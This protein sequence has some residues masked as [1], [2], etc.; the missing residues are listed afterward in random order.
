MEKKI[1][2]FFVVILQITPCQDVVPR[3][4]AR[5]WKPPWEYV[6]LFRIYVSL[7]TILKMLSVFGENHHEVVG[8][9]LISHYWC[10]KLRQLYLQISLQ[11]LMIWPVGKILVKI[12]ETGLKICHFFVDFSRFDW[13][14]TTGFP[15]FFDQNF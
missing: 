1:K 8:H 14:Q 10:Y 7:S 11:P 9:P 12:K 2:H 5:Y 3:K 4:K 15:T 6:S 13:F